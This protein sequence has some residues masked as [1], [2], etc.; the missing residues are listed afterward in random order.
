MWRIGG[1]YGG[2]GNG[3]SVCRRISDHAI[4]DHTRSYVRTRR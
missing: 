2:P 1:A 4:A 3:V